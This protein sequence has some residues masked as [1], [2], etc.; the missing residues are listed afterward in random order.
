MKNNSK[1]LIGYLD[2][3]KIPLV[4]ILL[5]MSGYVKVFEN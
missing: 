2:E 3:V 5:K 4:F 1:Q